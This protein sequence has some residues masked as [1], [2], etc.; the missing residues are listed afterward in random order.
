MKYLL[1]FLLS[2]PVY[3]YQ[4]IDMDSSMPNPVVYVKWD[5]GSSNCVLFPTAT[6]V[7][8]DT[9]VYKIDET[10][11]QYV[12]RSWTAK[13]VTPDMRKRCAM[14]AKKYSV[15]WTVAPYARKG[16]TYD[17]PIYNYNLF[18]TIK[19]RIGRAKAGTACGKFV[20]KYSKRIKSLTWRHIISG[21]ITG[22]T[23]CK[24]N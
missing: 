1:L 4:I 15:K 20:A 2:F 5:D 7:K 18:P 16:K 21:T 3:G 11:E 24:R 22:I 9:P 6:G 17:R 23:V 10:L 13:L 8:F 14:L 19:K 12:R